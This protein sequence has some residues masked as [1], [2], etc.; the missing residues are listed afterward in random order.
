MLPS[1]N[2]HDLSLYSL[3]LVILLLLHLLLLFFIR[4]MLLPLL[5]LFSWSGSSSSSS[6][7]SSNSFSSSSPPPPSSSSPPSSCSNSYSSFSL[8]LSFFIFTI[9]SD[10]FLIHLLISSMLLTLLGYI[11]AIPIRFGCSFFV[12]SSSD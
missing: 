8:V 12:F 7:A 1:S 5:V 2:H 9:N 11:F 4:L 3:H 6:F 10:G